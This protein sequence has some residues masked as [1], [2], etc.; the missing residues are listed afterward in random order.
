MTTMDP[1]RY[2]LQPHPGYKVSATALGILARIALIEG[3]T[4]QRYTMVAL[5]EGSGVS[6]ETLRRL[7]YRTGTFE[8]ET[9]ESVATALGVE[10]WSSLNALGLRLAQEALIP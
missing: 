3:E 9:L 2:T 1:S 6:V 4:G 10:G 8:A 5:A 7:I